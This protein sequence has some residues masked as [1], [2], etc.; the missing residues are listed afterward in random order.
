MAA[1]PTN[2]G[3]EPESDGWDLGGMGWGEGYG[4][5][6]WDVSPATLRLSN[7]TRKPNSRDVAVRDG[8][9]NGQVRWV[10]VGGLP[11]AEKGFA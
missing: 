9:F 2:V 8:Q 10:K 7:L 1:V 3:Y 11:G 5:V 4:R 6:G